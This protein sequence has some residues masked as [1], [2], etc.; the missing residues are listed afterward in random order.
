MS[1]YYYYFLQFWI[2]LQVCISKKKVYVGFWMGSSVQLIS[3]ETENPTQV[4]VTISPKPWLWLRQVWKRTFEALVPPGSKTTDSNVMSLAVYTDFRQ[5]EP[6]GANWST[7]SRVSPQKA[8]DPPKKSAPS[9]RVPVF[10]N[11]HQ[12]WVASVLSIFPNWWVTT[13]ELFWITLL[14]SQLRLKIFFIWIWTSCIFCV[15]IAYINP[16]ST[17]Y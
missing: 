6:P 8:L 12:Y 1:L 13:G 4:P 17:F 10:L 15:W 3:M 5:T 11:H 14:Y 16:L 9:R 7:D 2:Y